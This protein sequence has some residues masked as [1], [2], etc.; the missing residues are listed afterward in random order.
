M[1]KELVSLVDARAT[2]LGLNRS[3][4]LAHLARQDLLDRRDFVVREAAVS[5]SKTHSA[6]QIGASALAAGVSEL[7]G[8]AKTRPIQAVSPNVPIENRQA[9][10]GRPTKQT[11][12]P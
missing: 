11:K 9:S 8:E 7:A 2:A 4:Y 5:N 12:N 3:Q 10:E 6:D 1:P